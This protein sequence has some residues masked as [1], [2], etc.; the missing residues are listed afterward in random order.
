MTKPTATEHLAPLWT[1]LLG[2][3]APDRDA[4]F[5]DC[6]GTSVDAVHL[7][8]AIQE[9]LGV[10]VDAVDVVLLRTFGTIAD[11]VGQRLDE[12]ARGE[13]VPASER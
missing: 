3:T 5:F 7:A 2:G 4:D 11:L 10:S 1:E 8:A 13:H 9:N 6:G 12:A